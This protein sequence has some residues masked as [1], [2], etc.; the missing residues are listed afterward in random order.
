M[1]NQAS[2]LRKVGTKIEIENTTL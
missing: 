2:S 1:A